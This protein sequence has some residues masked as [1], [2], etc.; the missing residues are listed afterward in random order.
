MLTKNHCNG[1]ED[2][3]TSAGDFASENHHDH[4][5]ATTK[6]GCWGGVPPHKKYDVWERMYKKYSPRISSSQMNLEKNL[7]KI[8]YNS[9]NKHWPFDD[10]GC[11]YLHEPNIQIIY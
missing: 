5:T 7:K 10:L 6:V 8:Q 11:K 1:E 2:G 3:G 9:K 4:H